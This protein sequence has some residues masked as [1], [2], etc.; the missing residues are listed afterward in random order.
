[1]PHISFV[2]TP[3]PFSRTVDALLAEQAQR[4][5]DTLAVVAG[6]CRVTYA[7]LQARAQRLARR[8]RALG[9]RRGLR[10]GLLMSNR[11]EWVE[12]FFA[13]AIT[14]ATVVPISTWS[15]AAEL[16]FILADAQVDTLIA[17]ASCG[18]EEFLSV[19]LGL[20]PGAKDRPSGAWSSASVPALRQVFVVNAPTSLPCGFSRYDETLASDADAW[21]PPP[22]DGS[23]AGDV[24]LILYTSGSTSRPKAVPLRHFGLIENGFNIGERQGL[25]SEDRVLVAVPLFW[26]YGVA[27]ALM[28]TFT[29][30][31]TLILQERF[32]AGGAL[33]LIEAERCTSVYTLPAMTAAL[34]GHPS[35]TPARTR[36]LRKGLTIGTPQ[37][38]VRAATVLGAHGICNIYGSSETYGN[39][40]VTPTQWSLERRSRCQ[41]PPLPGM[42]LRLVDPE[43]GTPVPVGMPGVIEVRG[44]II[45]TY[46]GHS[47]ASN[48]STFTADGWYRTYDLG[49]LTADGDIV[50]IGRRS[51]M[52]KRGGINVSPAEVEDVLLQHAE[53]AAAAV[54]GAPDAA[55]GEEIV[56]FVVARPGATLAAQ[57]LIQHCR[58]H[59]SSY[60]APD[61]VVFR[62]ALPTTATGKVL[63]QALK[64]QA[65]V[66]TQGVSGGASHGA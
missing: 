53:V 63:R 2:M 38:V 54:V 35:F 49:E 65:S 32:E 61:H 24:A 51:E 42:S 14:G 20:L 44:Y 1:L 30:A 15:K 7:D 34:V 55:R 57:D 37:D 12:S 22:G 64:D 36:S 31:A 23:S 59:A 62:D 28:A 45:D 58:R 5:P 4:Y 52:I 47:V 19:L 29:H 43:D 46:L 18:Q 13:A 41:G 66:L 40:C 17:Q 27:N 11:V 60:K 50:F 16:E 6:G 48:A 26:A 33:D 56:A 3:P 8:L 25:T 39:C 10:V 9:V 21:A